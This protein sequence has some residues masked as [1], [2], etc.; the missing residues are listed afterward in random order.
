MLKR[1][2]KLLVKM[3][4]G[5]NASTT[6][7]ATVMKI[8]DHE[9]RNENVNHGQISIAK[10]WTLTIKSIASIKLKM[11][12][13]STKATV[14][15]SITSTTS[16]TAPLTMQEAKKMPT[17]STVVTKMTKS[18]WR[19]LQSRNR[20]GKRPLETTKTKNDFESVNNDW[21]VEQ[22][23]GDYAINY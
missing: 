9:N 16:K 3:E 11:P 10:T 13:T 14:M 23:Q 17:P 21:N 4:I 12:V 18:Q 2:M 22:G 6:N 8:E 7:I 19:G 15:T 20:Q 5:K 1:Q